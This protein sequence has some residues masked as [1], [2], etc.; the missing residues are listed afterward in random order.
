MAD[1][2]GA[3]CNYAV[4]DP[5]SGRCVIARA[6]HPPPA[7]VRPDGNVEFPDLPPGLPLGARGVSAL[8]GVSGAV[9]ESVE[10]LLEPGSILVLYTDGLI[11]SRNASIDVGMEKLADALSDGA[12]ESFGFHF[13]SDLISR[14]VPDPADDIAV[15]LARITGPD[16]ASAAM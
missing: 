15:L 14:L 9:F 16:P 13:V 7:L 3:T 10:L 6:G 8:S 11:E 12:A 2:A 1:E 5:E 4:L